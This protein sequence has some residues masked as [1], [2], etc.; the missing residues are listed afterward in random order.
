MRAI[1][2]RLV[3]L[4]LLGGL[5]LIVTGDLAASVAITGSFHGLRV[6]LAVHER[7]L[8][9]RSSPGE[10]EGTRRPPGS[11]SRPLPGGGESG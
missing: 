8:E 3:D 6:A 1:T 11:P 10:S 9:R 5:A 7:L 4:F 2:S